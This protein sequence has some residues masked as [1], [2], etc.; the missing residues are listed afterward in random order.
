MQI[1]CMATIIISCVPTDPNAHDAMHLYVNELDN[2]KLQAS[3]YT[4][5]LHTC[6]YQHFLNSS[7]S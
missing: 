4:Q 5:I 6:V 3:V 7:G 2:V 1:Q